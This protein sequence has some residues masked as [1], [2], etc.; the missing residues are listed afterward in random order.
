RISVPRLGSKQHF[1]RTLE[2]QGLLD[3]QIEFLPSDA[4]I[5]A[6]RARDQGL[7]RPELA[8]LLSYAKQVVYDQLLHSD[9]PEDPYLSKELQRYFPTPLQKKDTTA[10]EQ[11]P[12]KRAIIA[13]AVTYATINRM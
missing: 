8:V 3:R 5:A 6:H 11:H 1:I 7:T 10:I 2:A 13:T 4:E 9:I 12:L